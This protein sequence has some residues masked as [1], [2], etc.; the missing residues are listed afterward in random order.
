MAAAGLQ[1]AQQPE[2][3]QQ[4]QAMTRNALLR[5]AAAQQAAAAQL[6]QQLQGRCH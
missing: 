1:L 3:G 4:A 2:V 6:Q 5:L